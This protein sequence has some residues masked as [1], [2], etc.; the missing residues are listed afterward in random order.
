M[1]YRTVPRTAR[2]P[3]YGA[4]TFQLKDTERSN[5]EAACKTQK[6]KVVC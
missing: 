3:E 1:T 4:R 6:N 2:V 5:I